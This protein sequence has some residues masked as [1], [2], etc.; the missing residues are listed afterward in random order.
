[1]VIEISNL[2]DPVLRSGGVCV[3]VFAIKYREIKMSN[4]TT[5]IVTILCALVCLAKESD[6]GMFSMPKPVEDS[7]KKDAE[8]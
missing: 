4:F 5:A 7:S 8:R 1:M 6:Q 2:F 3:L